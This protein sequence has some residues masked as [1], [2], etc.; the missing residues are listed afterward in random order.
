M[1]N[2]RCSL[3]PRRDR[4]RLARIAATLGPEMELERVLERIAFDC[5]YMQPGEKMRKYKARCGIRF[6]DLDSGC[7]PPPDLPP[8]AV[9]LRVVGGSG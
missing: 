5:H 7:P 8:S 3:C 1:V 2:I 4:Y 9:A 6:T